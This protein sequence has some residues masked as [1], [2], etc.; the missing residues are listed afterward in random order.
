MRNKHYRRISRLRDATIWRCETLTLDRAK[1]RGSER[2]ETAFITSTLALVECCDF[3][4]FIHYA[5]ACVWYLLAS[6]LGLA[7]LK[8]Q[9]RMETLL[10]PQRYLTSTFYAKIFQRLI[11]SVGKNFC[12]S[13]FFSRT[14][15]WSEINNLWEGI[16][17]IGISFLLSFRRFSFHN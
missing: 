15:L 5:C 11:S 9:W 17:Q 3:F 12:A 2:K 13:L 6:T 14:S 10:K 1:M 8:I 7:L 4:S 16:R